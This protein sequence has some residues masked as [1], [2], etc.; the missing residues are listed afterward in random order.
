MILLP[1]PPRADAGWR[2]D[3]AK[4]VAAGADAFGQR[5]LRNQIDLDLAAIILF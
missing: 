1:F 4:A 2:E 5:A 3:A